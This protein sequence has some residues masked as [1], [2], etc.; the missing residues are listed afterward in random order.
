MLSRAAKLTP[1]DD[2]G[3]IGPKW[4]IERVLLFQICNSCEWSLQSRQK[5]RRRF[6]KAISEHLGVEPGDRVK[7]FVHP[8]GSVVL[9]AKRPATALRGIVKARRSVS[10]EDINEAIANAA[11]GEP[12]RRLR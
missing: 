2:T 7:F 1:G 11:A 12:E 6:P 9:L 3:A 8:D 5:D 10:I 4:L